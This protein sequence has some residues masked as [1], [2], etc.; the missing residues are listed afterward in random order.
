MGAF[1]ALAVI[2]AVAFLVWR[3]EP[4]SP[5][6][7]VGYDGERAPET[8]PTL[9]AHTVPDGWACVRR[10]MRG[11]EALVARSLLESNG[12]AAALESTSGRIADVSTVNP[13]G[14]GRY[15][16]W[17]PESDAEAAEALL[18]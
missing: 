8:L 4:G 18:S 1:I 9:G 16:L 13:I 11:S 2:A 7:D 5:E 17:V 14:V 12:V 10:D 3:L 6:D 15:S